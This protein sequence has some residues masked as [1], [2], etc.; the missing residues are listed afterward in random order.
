MTDAELKMVADHLGHN[1]NIHLD[2]Y[3]QQ[4]SMI[5]R[6]KVARILVAVDNGAVDSF[7]GRNLQSIDM[8][9]K[10]FYAI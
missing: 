4:T 9:G 6:T 10:V 3:R 8:D 1:V 7:Q 5:E 2:I